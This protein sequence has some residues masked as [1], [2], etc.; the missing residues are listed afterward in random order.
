M[1]LDLLLDEL[2]Y[3]RPEDVVFFCKVLFIHV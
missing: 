2:P 3:C 1:G